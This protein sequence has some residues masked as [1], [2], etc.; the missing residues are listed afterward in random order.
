MNALTIPQDS[1]I[2]HDNQLRTTSHKVAEAFGKLHKNVMQ[3]LQSLDCSAQFL[4][5]NFSAVKFNHKG[6]EYDA[7]EMTKDGFMFLVMGFTGKKAAQIKEAFINAFNAMA[8]ELSKKEPH[9]KRLTLTPEQKCHIKAIIADKCKADSTAYQTL[10]TKLNSN[11][12]VAKYDE[13][14]AINYP[15]ACQFLGAKPLEGE[16]LA[17][18]EQQVT[19]AELPEINAREH[20]VEWMKRDIQLEGD[21]AIL[22]DEKAVSLALEFHK[23]AREHIAKKVAFTCVSPTNGL[24]KNEAKQI[25]KSVTLNASLTARFYQQIEQMRLMSQA[26]LMFNQKHMSEMEAILKH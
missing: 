6:N 17:H 18:G 26:A 12:G 10:Y 24:N 23:L 2:F 16:Y 25:I 1:I 11:F 4:T 19:V 21:L 5:A 15:A 13:I 22:A 3:K 7:Y 14:L 9:T 8:A 20:M